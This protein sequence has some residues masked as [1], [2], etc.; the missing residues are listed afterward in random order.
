MSMLIR[1]VQKRLKIL[2]TLGLC[3]RDDITTSNLVNRAIRTS[4]RRNGRL[5][6]EAHHVRKARHSRRNLG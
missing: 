6:G 5:P 1:L 2:K 3:L 4:T